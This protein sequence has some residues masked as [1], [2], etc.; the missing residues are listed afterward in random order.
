[1]RERMV[2][3]LLGLGEAFK[4]F[5]PPLLVTRRGFGCERAELVLLTEEERMD[6][7]LKA[8]R[9][10]DLHSMQRQREQEWEVGSWICIEDGRMGCFDRN[11]QQPRVYA[12]EGEFIYLQG[13]RNVVNWRLACPHTSYLVSMCGTVS[14]DERDPGVTGDAA[15]PIDNDGPCRFTPRSSDGKTRLLAL[16]KSF[17]A[18]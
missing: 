6:D 7:R 10:D 14:L 18:E 4:S 12:L 8:R 17:H 3:R 1:M 2:P 15:A 11:T 9:C 13:Q 16:A 5:G